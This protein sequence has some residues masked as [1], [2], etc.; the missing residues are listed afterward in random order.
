MSGPIVTLLTDFGWRDGYVGAMKG[1]LLSRCPDVRL[2]DL[3]HEI[4]PGDVAGAAY[5]LRQA[6]P[7]YPEGSVHLVVVDPGVG[8]KRRGLAAR[9]NGR[10][11]VAPDNGVLTGVLEGQAEVYELRESGLW[12][13]DPS[14]VF[15]GRDVFAP[16]AA[17]LAAGGALSEVG[18]SVPA[19]G[20]VRA[21]WPKPELVGDEHRGEVVYVDRFG[22]LVTNLVLDPSLPAGGVATVGDRALSL[23]RTYSDVERGE[24]LAL[25]G[26][27]GLLEIACNLGDASGILGAGRGL[28]VS[29]RAQPRS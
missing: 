8:S 25:R 14:P 24:L 4:V 23:R 18:P 6:A 19:D 20:L 22:N 29:F 3:T 2:V 11:F 7:Y 21:S 9:V 17:H 13:E 16:V 5:V 26:S 15:H 27:S 28:V 1:V 10:F 12:R